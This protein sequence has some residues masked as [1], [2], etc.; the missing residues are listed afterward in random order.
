MTQGAHKVAA[1]R[2]VHSGRVDLTSNTNA[3][4]L[5]SGS[6]TESPLP[7]F[8]DRLKVSPVSFPPPIAADW[9]CGN[10]PLMNQTFHFNACGS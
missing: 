2:E 3:I 5:Q 9:P 10:L 8:H 6:G 4:G 1:G 7:A